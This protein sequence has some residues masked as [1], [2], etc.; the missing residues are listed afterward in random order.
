M[1]QDMH[2]M[3]FSL[4]ASIRPPLDEPGRQVIVDFGGGVVTLA[5]ISVDSGRD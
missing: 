1:N 2:E 5:L 3:C 4:I